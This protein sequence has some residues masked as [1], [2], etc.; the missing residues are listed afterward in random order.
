LEQKTV[1]YLSTLLFIVA[2]FIAYFLGVSQRTVEVYT[3]VTSYETKGL[4]DY[5]DKR[6]FFRGIE[7]N[8]GSANITCSGD[9]VF[10]GSKAATEADIN[11]YERSGDGDFY[12]GF[13]FYNKLNFTNKT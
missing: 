1:T 6:Y 8:L 5:A 10:D 12:D 2:L 3:C 11:N 7:C 9:I 4:L 13:T